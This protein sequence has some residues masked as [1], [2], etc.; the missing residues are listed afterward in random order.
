MAAARAH[1]VRRVIAQS[2]AFAY[3]PTGAGLWSEDDPLMT[4]VGEIVAAVDALERQTVATEGVDGLVLRY[5]FFYGPGTGY[6]GSDGAA[7]EDVRKRRFPIVGKGT[8]VWSW[9][10]VDD[11]AGATVAALERGAPGIYNVVDDEPAPVSEWLPVYA[12]ALGAKKPFRAPVWVAR[13]A[14]GRVGVHY[15][16]TLQGADNSKAKRELGWAPRYRSWRDGFRRALG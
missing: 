15:M 2:I 8:G 16:T 14:S 1:G 6:A 4:E 5:G 12:E 7:A 10:H 3:R 13:L 11:A 9:I